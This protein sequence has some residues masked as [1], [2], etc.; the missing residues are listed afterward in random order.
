M[1][2]IE[3]L[4][5]SL[6]EDY[7]RDPGNKVWNLATKHRAINKGYTKIQEELN[8]NEWQNEAN[9]T[10]LTVIG[11]ELYVLPDDFIRMSIVTHNWTDLAETS[12]KITRERDQTPQSGIPRHYYIYNNKLWLY[13]VPDAVQTLNMMF[14]KNEPTVSTTQDSSMPATTDDAALKWA[15]YQLFL[16][17]R[18]T[19]SAT[20]FL[21]DYER[22]INNLRGTLLFDDENTQL[23]YER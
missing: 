23:T 15:A 11:S 9:E 21:Q 6:N 19:N 10:R 13:P 1:T 18:D 5:T 4:V 16:G 20:I 17:L 7:V 8:W 3:S 14:Y 2:T 12:R 22:E